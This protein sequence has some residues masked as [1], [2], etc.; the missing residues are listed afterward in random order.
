MGETWDIK[1]VFSHRQSLQLVRWPRRAWNGQESRR[2]RQS[3]GMGHHCW[4]FPLCSSEISAQ[5]F[6]I[7]AFNSLSGRL[8]VSI[9]LSSSGVLSRAFVRN[10]FLCGVLLHVL[11]LWSLFCRTQD[12]SSSGSGDYPGV[13]GRGL[14]LL[15]TSWWAGLVSSLGGLGQDVSY[16]CLER[17]AGSGRL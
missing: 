12:G 9:S 11:C 4:F 8:P 5:I 2:S 1:Q 10:I 14:G 15:Q 6:T 17:A 3:G 7:I 16:V 13:D